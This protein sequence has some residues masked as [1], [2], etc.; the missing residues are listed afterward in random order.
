MTI[1]PVIPNHFFHYQDPKNITSNQDQDS[2]FEKRLQCRAELAADPENGLL[3]FQYAQLLYDQFNNEKEN[4]S[5]K[6]PPHY[7]L[8]LKA[9]QEAKRG[10]ELDPQYD[11]GRELLAFLLLNAGDYKGAFAILDDQIRKDP[12][13]IHPKLVK[14]D[15]LIQIKK[16]RLA[17]RIC[18]KI[19]RHD[20]QNANVFAKRAEIMIK[21]RGIFF[22]NKYRRAKKLVLTAL[23]IDPDCSRAIYL[24]AFLLEQQ[25]DLPIKEICECYKHLLKIDR[26]DKTAILRLRYFFKWQRNKQR[27]KFLKSMNDDNDF[28][29]KKSVSRND[30]IVIFVVIAIVLSS[31]GRLVTMLSEKKSN[32]KNAPVKVQQESIPKP[33]VPRP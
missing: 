15:F 1:L 4:S 20:P 8:L 14:V 9:I 5:Q 18:R 24:Y 10:C 27:S 31:L 25:K 21:R 32:D 28:I 11:F 12:N 19:L 23:R 22:F 6:N 7:S 30:T 26:N 17:D 33:P 13:A 2:F 3:H 29:P 16:W